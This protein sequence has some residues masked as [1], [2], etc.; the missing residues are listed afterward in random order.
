M[1]K[2]LKVILKHQSHLCF[3]LGTEAINIGSCDGQKRMLSNAKPHT[4]A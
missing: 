3:S 1:K 4:Y 2:K